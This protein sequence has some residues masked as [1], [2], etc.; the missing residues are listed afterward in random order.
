VP[1]LIAFVSQQTGLSQKAV[2]AALAKNFPHT[3]ALLQAIPLSSVTAELRTS[4]RS[5]P[6]R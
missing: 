1:K 4:S 3:L 5:C 2:V 6:R